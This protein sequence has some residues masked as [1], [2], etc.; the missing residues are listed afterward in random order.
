VPSRSRRSAAREDDEDIVDRRMPRV[1]ILQALGWSH[2]DAVGCFVATV[3][4]AVIL[5]NVLFL[6]SG[7]HPAPMFKT[8][9][10][11][12]QSAGARIV[13]ALPRARPPQSAAPASAERSTVEIVTDIQRELARRGFY[14]AAIDGRYGA[15]TEAAIR[16][17]EQ[18]AGLK[19]STGP[20][21]ALLRAI[22]NSGALSK[23]KKHS[24]RSAVPPHNDAIAALLE[25]SDRVR[26]VQRA[27]TDYGYGQITPTGV[28]DDDTQAAIAKF[29]RA[30]HLP[31]TG[32]VSERV[33][34]ELASVTGRPLE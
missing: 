9:T 6:Q 10:I 31:V 28:V 29:E 20:S 11:P 3:A 24:E 19:S 2:R 15:K 27:L 22:R 23:S 1:F 32:Q 14:E 21:E 16:D 8:G 25:A 30:R 26:N 13:P 17:F 12:T 5:I 18:A 4:A 34:R 7:Q 33:T